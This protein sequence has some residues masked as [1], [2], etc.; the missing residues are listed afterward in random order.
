MKILITGSTGFVGRNLV[1][2]LISNGHEVLELTRNINK[3]N[4]FF[5]DKTIKLEIQDSEFKYKILK[6]N[7]EIVIH[8]ASYLSSSDGFEEGKK[9]IKTNI[10]FLYKVLDS[11]SKTQLK[12]FV[13]TGSFSEYKDCDSNLKPAYLY[14]ATKTSSRAF[15]DY[16]ST[17]YHFKYCT[18][19]PYTIYGV[20]DP[21]RKIIDIIYESISSNKPL[22]LSPGK[23]ILDFIHVDDVTDFYLLL[24]NNSHK[25]SNKSNFKLG[26]G[27]GH[28]LRQLANLIEEIT[29]KKTN[30]NWGGIKYRSSDIMYAVA[31]LD[32]IKK[33]FE[34]SPSITLKEGLS[35]RKK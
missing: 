12:L 26:S 21:A 29:R 31:D 3:S 27:V 5:G 33:I 25:F 17:T 34:W 22:N 32:E 35:S 16:Y 19:I 20:K 13:N 15:L 9:L 1:P 24:V 2:K 6:F 10:F 7:A 30:I 18:V 11:I 28:S 23:Q 8:L 14:A 4:K